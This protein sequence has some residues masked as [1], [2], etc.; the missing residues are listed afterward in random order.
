[1]ATITAADITAAQNA[2]TSSVIL[3]GNTYSA[4][5][6]AGKGT[7]QSFLS[8]SAVATTVL[9]TAYNYDYGRVQFRPTLTALPH[10]F[11]NTK[12]S[13]LSY[14]VSGAYDTSGFATANQWKAVQ[15]VSMST[16]FWGPIAFT[17]GYVSFSNA[18]SGTYGA[19]GAAYIA[20]TQS[21]SV[22]KTFVYTKDDSGNVR[23]ILH[24]SALTN[25]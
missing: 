22:D 9:S 19:G 1:M 25:N 6:A 3:I 2:W 16:Q 18:A 15:F 10:T 20:G 8:A 23:I 11:R 14:F 7:Q 21:V 4:S 13:A 24:Y 17:Q 12:E 5:F